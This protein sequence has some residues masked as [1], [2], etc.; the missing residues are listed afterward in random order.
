MGRGANLQEY[1]RAIGKKRSKACFSARELNEVMP[2]V[3]TKA[4][5]EKIRLGRWW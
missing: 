2:V 5:H 1:R 3:H 4:W